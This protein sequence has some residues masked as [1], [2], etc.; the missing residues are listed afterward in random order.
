V[1]LRN[2]CGQLVHA[3]AYIGIISG[4]NLAPGAR[5]DLLED[6]EVDAYPLG[7]SLSLVGTGSALADF[8]WTVATGTPGAVNTGQN[9]GPPLPATPPTPA[10][11][12]GLQPLWINEINTDP[13]NN[14]EYWEVAA[15]PGASSTG[16]TISRCQNPILDGTIRD[17]GCGTARVPIPALKASAGGLLVA[18]ANIVYNF[19]DARDQGLGLFDPCG[20]LTQLVTYQGDLLEEVSGVTAVIIDTLLPGGL[21]AS[22]KPGKSL[23]LVGTGAASADFTWAVTGQSA[24]ASNPG[25]SLAS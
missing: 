2:P 3:V 20:K 10:S 11:C 25:Q 8:K 9:S 19:V 6:L 21:L 16:W 17:L 5:T 18:S 14:G 12:A 24:D 7:R 15:A 1:G 4:G 23:G 13:S 22:R